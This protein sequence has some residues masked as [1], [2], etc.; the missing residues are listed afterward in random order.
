MP[1]KLYLLCKE[2]EVFGMKNN[3]IAIV[4]TR[5]KDRNIKHNYQKYTTIQSHYEKKRLR[6]HFLPIQYIVNSNFYIFL[7]SKYMPNMLLL[8]IKN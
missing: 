5:A 1:V 3:A 6:C 7:S 2:V 8:V 4:I